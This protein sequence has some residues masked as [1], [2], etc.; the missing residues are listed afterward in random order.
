VK[1]VDFG[2][3]QIVIRDGKGRKDRV[4][5]LPAAVARRRA[6][7]SRRVGQASEYIKSCP[8]FRRMPQHRS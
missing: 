8:S 5:M 3:S 6:P 1:D 4:T 2:A 7:L